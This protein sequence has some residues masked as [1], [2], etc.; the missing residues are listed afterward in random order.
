MFMY[1]EPKKTNSTQNNSN[2]R[3]CHSKHNLLNLSKTKCRVEI[4]SAS[5]NSQWGWPNTSGPCGRGGWVVFGNPSGCP[6]LACLPDLTLLRFSVGHCFL[7]KYRL[8]AKLLILFLQDSQLNLQKRQQ[9]EWVVALHKILLF[10]AVLS[11]DLAL[12]AYPRCSL[13]EEMQWKCCLPGKRFLFPTVGG[14]VFL[15]PP[16]LSFG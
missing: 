10:W 11:G 3:K 9:G 16:F 13:T 4:H 6:Q 7:K 14:P 1:F 12:S 15:L 2:W 8:T 5:L